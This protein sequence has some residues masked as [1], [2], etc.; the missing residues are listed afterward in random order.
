MDKTEKIESERQAK[1]KVLSDEAE[2]MCAR[3]NIQFL[4]AEEYIDSMGGLS[5]D[6]VVTRDGSRSATFI[7]ATHVV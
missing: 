4:R 5:E 3:N 7:P 1:L 6:N 2:A